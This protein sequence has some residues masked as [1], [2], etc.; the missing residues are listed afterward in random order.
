MQNIANVH[1]PIIYCHLRTG[2]AEGCKVINLSECQWIYP[3]KIHYFPLQEGNFY[4]PQVG[5]VM[6]CKMS[7]GGGG[8]LQLLL[9]AYCPRR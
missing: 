6:P 9:Q 4:Y 2:M 1:R 8:G 3:K 5:G 7:D